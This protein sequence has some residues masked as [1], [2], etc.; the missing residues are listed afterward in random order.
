M[1]SLGCS[2][3]D[4]ATR[5]LWAPPAVARFPDTAEPAES[6][7][8]A[9]Q[10][11]PGAPA[12]TGPNLTAPLPAGSAG[13]VTPLGS[14][15]GAVDVRSDARAMFERDHLLEVRVELAEDDWN[16][17]REE[18]MSLGSILAPVRDSVEYSKFPATVSVDG[19]LYE[20][21]VIRKKGFINSLSAL[22]P[23]LKL[24]LE[25]ATRLT[26]NNDLQDPSHTRQCLAY[27]LFEQAG[28]PAP[29]CNLAH[30]IVNGR[31]LGVYTHV[32]DI[33]KPM[34]S[35]YFADTGGNLYEGQLADFDDTHERLQ[36]K[37]NE[38]RADRTDVAR[39]VAALQTSDAELVAALEPI[40]DLD[41]FRT[42]WAVETL[43]GQW[44]GYSGNGNNYFA[45]HDPTTDRFVF[46]PWG[47]DEAFVGPLRVGSQ[48]YE[49][50]VYANGLLA[51]RLYAIPE[52][53]E[54]FRER[55]GALNDTLWNEARLLSGLDR[56]ARL[57]GLAGEGD[58]AALEAHRNFVRTHGTELRRALEQP[59]PASP[60]PREEPVGDACAGLS[61][62]ISGRFATEWSLG[63]LE[64]S[65][66]GTFSVEVSPDG[67]VHAGTFEGGAGPDSQRDK[68]TILQTSALPDG[69]ALLVQVVLPRVSFH[70][71]A[72]AFH[73]LETVGYAG[74]L[75]VGGGF[76]QIGLIGDGMVQLDEAGQSPGN[77]V[78]GS[79][80]GELHQ[81]ACAGL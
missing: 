34:L 27:D 45:Y 64:T 43:L 50:S 30:V 61:T 20:D 53:R 22:R 13:P 51:Q 12:A 73:A 26:L 78:S 63:P 33:K 46:I 48:P 29:R 17:L 28:V 77:A 19:Q 38:A 65:T 31:D 4:D 16:Q 37:T 5:L 76:H 71:G 35:R 25:G 58:A 74:V 8:P 11:P 62:P 59:A 79:F 24:E 7:D 23:S 15:A 39:L 66:V 56:L 41:R 80:S 2:S 70:P 52:E 42:F 47:A 54:R 10:R 69:R 40:L 81:W 57:T 68:A 9:A 72:H 44:D 32:E 75:Q 67:I 36:L 1:A 6:V 3:N 21:V 55:L 60:P 49:I 14:G 18:G